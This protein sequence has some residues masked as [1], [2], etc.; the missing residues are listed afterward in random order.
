M[1][2]PL[3]WVRAE[4]H[5]L[6]PQGRTGIIQAGNHVANTV[7]TQHKIV[8]LDSETSV[9]VLIRLPKIETHSP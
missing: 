5:L 2:K 3:G 7:A 6:L 8:T 4:R 9:T 1:E